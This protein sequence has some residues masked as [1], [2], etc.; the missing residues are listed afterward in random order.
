M[1]TIRIRNLRQEAQELAL[2]IG[3]GLTDHAID[4]FRMIPPDKGVTEYGDLKK[5]AEFFGVSQDTVYQWNS[6]EGRSGALERASKAR[7]AEKKARRERA[8]K[9]AAEIQRQADERVMS[10]W[11]EG[12]SASACTGLGSKCGMD[13]ISRLRA[14]YGTE[15][16]PYRKE[17]TIK[18]RRL[19]ALL[20]VH[21]AQMNA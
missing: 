8:K 5:I 20:A 14:K 21:A 16:V 7:E 13:R 9:Q 12:A 11:R 18:T 3:L 15:A 1:Q 2:S 4:L 10:A 17:D 6:R 19:N